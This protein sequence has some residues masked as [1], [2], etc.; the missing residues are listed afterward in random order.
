MSKPRAIIDLGTNTFQLLIADNNPENGKLR[1]LYNDHRPVG[2]GK[3]AMNTGLLQLD[4]MARSLEALER[5]LWH[6]QDKGCHSIQGIGTSVLRNAQNAGAFIELVESQLG[7]P[8]QVISGN[9]EA[10]Y[11]FQGVRHSLPD[12]WN[13]VSMVMDIGGGSVEFII[14][15]GSEIMFKT[16][17]E[18]G[19]L[20]LQSL[21]HV[22]GEFDLKIED[23]LDLH[24]YQELIDVLD[25]IAFYR[26]SHLIGAA[27]AF[28]TL[29]DVQLAHGFLTK[30]EEVNVLDLDGFYQL[31]NKMANMNVVGRQGIPG[32][33]AFRAS[34]IP[35]ANSLIE[36]ILDQGIIDSLWMSMYSLKE[37]YWYSTQE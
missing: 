21:F 11:I 13:E 12:S 18:L 26:P 37:G 32:M 35:Y 31:K 30:I 1:V 15:Q 10:D 29:A 7:I 34:M 16:S 27:G 25:A 3:G 23:E 8:I 19:G 33:K 5:F 20:K 36:P 22:D 14:F 17:L 28:E 9:Q 2:L 24:I 6:A 4:A